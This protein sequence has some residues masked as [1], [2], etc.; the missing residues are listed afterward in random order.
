M[1]WAITHGLATLPRKVVVVVLI[2]FDVDC[3]KKPSIPGE[4]VCTSSH[5]FR[6]L[7]GRNKMLRNDSDSLT[8]VASILDNFKR[9]AS[10]N[11]LEVD[12]V[13]RSA[14][15][16][17]T[18]L[19]FGNDS[20]EGSMNEHVK[21]KKWSLEGT[22]PSS[23]VS[24]LDVS[25]IESPWE[26]RRLKKELIDAKSK[27]ASLETRVSQL[28]ALRRELEVVFESEKNSLLLQQGRDKTMIQT[29]E[30]RVSQLR[31]R[32]SDC[33]DSLARKLKDLED[34][35]AQLEQAIITLRREK[36]Q[37]T[38][39]M[40]EMKRSVRNAENKNEDYEDE[41]KKLKSIISQNEVEKRRSS[42]SNESKLNTFQN[43][44]LSLELREAQ[45]TIKD[46]QRQLEDGNEASAIVKAQQQK[47]FKLPEM[48]RE[49][50]ILRKDVV[51]LRD[52]V[53]NK[54]L[55]EEEV[56]DLRQ[57]CASSDEQ[58][59]RLVQLEAHQQRLESK[60]R[61]W[62]KL[63]KDFCP[64]ASDNDVC[65]S[66]LRKHLQELQQSEL[67][68]SSEVADLQNKW[69][70][71]NSALAKAQ[72]EISRLSKE[73]SSLKTTQ[74]QQGN[75]IRRW[76][77]KLALVTGE[78]NSYREQLDSYEKELTMP[79]SNQQQALRPRIESL[80]KSLDGYR[81]LVE[82]LE[83]DLTSALGQGGAE[84]LLEKIRVISAEKDALSAEKI[85][86]QKRVDE[87]QHQMEQ[88]VL[89]GDF[90]SGSSRILHLRMNPVA[91]AEEEREKEV[92]MLKTEVAKLRERVKV[93]QEGER[94][95]ITCKVDK[96]L[97]TSN[98]QEVQELQ[99]KIKSADIMMQR[100]KE[101]FKKTSTEF[102]DCVY[103]LLG[104][105]VDRLQNKGGL[106]RLSS[107]YAE[108]PDD[109]L[110]FKM[111]DNVTFNLLETPFSASLGD[112]IDTHLHQQGSL[113]V[114]NAAVTMDLFSR[115]SMM[116]P[117]ASADD[118]D[119]DPIVVLD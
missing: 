98:S 69:K 17:S 50:E 41:I 36:N 116:V 111:Q 96:R 119:D 60:L 30:S 74:D 73:V 37:L 57:K 56:A 45:R 32:E 112:L 100:L 7:T 70:C 68:L 83:A 15:T 8:C 94:D 40:F 76:Q 110:L 22:P 105:K 89:K 63:V 4:I 118:D 67:L 101:A 20:F 61:D 75:L 28:H 95:D 115:Q 86:L 18:R 93:L 3:I 91:S 84:G 9:K 85:S 42:S 26:A 43:E 13:N 47:L 11:R 87:L 12:E 90:S 10:P 27:I 52:A 79:V 103:N 51:N 6:G 48:E 77:R 29:L 92:T 114:F 109:Y 66:L 31:R 106:F 23:D 25:A 38:D 71:G 102:R 35:N 14:S 107:M 49:L 55:L 64:S 53:H 19:N 62:E 104:Y 1:A 117:S 21:R 58:I 39:E 78:R 16:V 88:Q 80:E 97:M 46:L 99:E 82:N 33:R 113:P 34:Q 24:H 81:E 59:T 54:L 2:S 5:F 65:P 44:Q 108:S 72:S